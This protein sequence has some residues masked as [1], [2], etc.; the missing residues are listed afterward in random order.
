MRKQNWNVIHV[1]WIQI[2]SF[3]MCF[4]ISWSSC[5]D[6]ELHPF[7]HIERGRCVVPPREKLPP[8]DLSSLHLYFSAPPAVPDQHVD[9]GLLSGSS[10]GKT[11]V[12]E[13]ERCHLPPATKT[14]KGWKMNTTGFH[15]LWFKWNFLRYLTHTKYISA[16]TFFFQFPCIDFSSHT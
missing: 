1:F 8:S 13:A 16:Y 3:L 10:T 4:E 11:G 12:I 14:G 2:V 5:P 6:W 7:I 9:H 15:L